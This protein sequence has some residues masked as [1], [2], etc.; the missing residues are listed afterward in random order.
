MQ[1]VVHEALETT[2]CCLGV[3]VLVVDLVHERGIDALARGGDD[4]LLRPAL[5]VGGGPVAAGEDARGLDDDVGAD[6]APGD[7][8]RIPLGEGLDLVVADVQHVAVVGDVLGPDAVRRVVLEKV[9]QAVERH[10]VVRRHHLDVPRS[11]AALVNSIP[12]RPKPFTPTLTA[13]LLSH[14]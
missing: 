6:V 9:C 5:D 1:L 11:I 10:Q 7:L 2:S 12:I 3:V 8:G 14:L 13:T 4:D